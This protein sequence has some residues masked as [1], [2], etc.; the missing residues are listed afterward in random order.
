MDPGLRRDD[1]GNLPRSLPPLLPVVLLHCNF[2]AHVAR[3]MAQCVAFLRRHDAIGLHSSFVPMQVAL[4]VRR[5]MRLS[6]R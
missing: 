1:R 3:M 4:G 2:P 5:T 6:S